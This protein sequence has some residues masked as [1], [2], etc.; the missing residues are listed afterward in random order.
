MTTE[1]R[2]E[3]SRVQSVLTRHL[4]GIHDSATQIQSTQTTL[5]RRID[6]IE[7]KDAGGSGMLD[8]GLRK[9]E[10]RIGLL[11]Q[12]GQIVASGMSD[13]LKRVGELEGRLD[14]QEAMIGGCQDAVRKVKE[15]QERQTRQ[16]QSIGQCLVDIKSVGTRL[17][18]LEAMMRDIKAMLESPSAQGTPAPK[19]SG[20]KAPL[21]PL[22]QLP[23]PPKEKSAEELAGAHAHADVAQ[24]AT[25][26]VPTVTETRAAKRQRLGAGAE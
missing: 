2:T 21:V 17:D 12:R 26:A 15:L 19:A 1:L 25:S 16:E 6:A 13:A 14:F 23:T 7:S 22:G 20:Q 11:E 5:K 10:S 4:V 9:A 8:Q 3:L 18:G 24:P